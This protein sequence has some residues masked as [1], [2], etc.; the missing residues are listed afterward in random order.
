MLVW[1]E[2]VGAIARERVLVLP[3]GVR[4][5]ISVGEVAQGS[6]MEDDIVTTL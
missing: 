4:Q 2:E 1:V 6:D 5:R 3:W